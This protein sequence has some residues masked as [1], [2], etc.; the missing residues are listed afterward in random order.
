[1]SKD[2]DGLLQGVHESGKAE[3]GE[4]QHL[5]GSRR[6]YRAKSQASENGAHTD[7]GKALFHSNS[8]SSNDSDAS[9]NGLLEVFVI[10]GSHVVEDLSR[11]NYDAS[12]NVGEADEAQ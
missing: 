9:R 6:L 5:S 12:A 10:E 11:E 8:E 3:A 7:L 2:I 4:R 1:M